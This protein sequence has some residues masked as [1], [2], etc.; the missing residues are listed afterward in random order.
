MEIYGQQAPVHF[1]YND[2]TCELFPA[3]ESC[4]RSPYILYAAKM[5]KQYKMY[6]INIIFCGGEVSENDVRMTSITGRRKRG[7]RPT[8]PTAHVRAEE[9]ALS[10]PASLLT[11]R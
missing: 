5:Y 9:V 10:S 1:L 3:R 4:I 8:T 11:D 6:E 2:V 7:R